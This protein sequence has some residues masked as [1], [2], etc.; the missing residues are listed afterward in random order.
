MS[1]E[2]VCPLRLAAALAACLALA[3]CTGNGTG[4]GL[5]LVSQDQLADMGR[6]DWQRLLATTPTSNNQSYQRRAEQVS[7]RLLRA[8]GLNAGEWEVRVFKD[9]QV[10][11]FALPGQKIGVYEGLFNY[12]K[13]DAQLAAVI[14]HEIAHNLQGHAAER[15]STQMATEAGTGILGAVLGASG[16]GGSD[17]IAAA[18]GTGAQ[19]GLILPYSRNQELEADRIGLLMMA[20]AGYDPQAAIELWQ[21]MKEAGAQPPTFLS[22]HPGTEDRIAALQKLMPEAKAAYKPS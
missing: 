21:N 8:A 18:L 14:G 1:S 15:V 3:G 19:Y 2:T 13:T 4:L 17:L 6:Q 10:N 5:N 12:A 20:R 16:I 7:M 11:A 22:T 9:D